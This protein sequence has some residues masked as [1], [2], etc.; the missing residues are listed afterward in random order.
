[1]IKK[2]RCK[3]FGH[4]WEYYNFTQP[5]II[6]RGQTRTYAEHGRRCKRCGFDEYRGVQDFINY[7]QKSKEQQK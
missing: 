1:M 7:I 5:V 2:L 3:I 6:N 4:S